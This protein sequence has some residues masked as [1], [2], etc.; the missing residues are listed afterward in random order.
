MEKLPV[1]F[2]IFNRPE[3]AARSFERIREYAPS[4]LFIACDGP[5]PGRPEEEERVKETRGR[6][7]GMIDWPCEVETLFQPGNL[8]CG[9]GV[10]AAID[11]FFS[12]VEEGVI[13]EDDCVA[14]LSFFDF[15]SD[16][17]AR[18]RD[19]QRIGM[20]AGTN[21]VGRLEGYPY[22]IIFS[23]YKSCW[24]W[25]SWRRSWR[26]M[27]FGMDWR[28]S[29]QAGDIIAN[30]GFDAKDFKIWKFKL[31][32]I[33]RGHVSAWDWQWYFSLAAQNRLCIYPAH[34]LVSNYGNTPEATHTSLSDITL[35]SAPIHFPLSVPPYVV[36]SREFDRKFYASSNTLYLKLNRA[37]P[38]ALKAKLKKIIAK[39][40]K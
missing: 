36:P 10:Y 27:D 28:K 25:A 33:D 30:S 14:E 22:S 11:W 2:V 24:G 7:L 5:R 31:R 3:T 12:R 39:C 26:D 38:P 17:L 8:G 40:R 20:I 19:D 16:M 32:C 6:I 29:P 35:P 4:R 37:V 23:K 15:A 9:P 13:L 1:L 34:N 21:P 18:Y